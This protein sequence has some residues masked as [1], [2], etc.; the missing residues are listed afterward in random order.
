MKLKEINKAKRKQA[1]KYLG[2][3]KTKGK[4]DTEVFAIMVSAAKKGVS[5]N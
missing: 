1:V 3:E 4:S 5:L 2:S